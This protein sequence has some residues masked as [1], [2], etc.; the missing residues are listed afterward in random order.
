MSDGGYSPLEALL[1]GLLTVFVLWTID[2]INEME[3]TLEVVC[4]E[5]ECPE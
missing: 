3:A 2:T 1:I 4:E 5:V